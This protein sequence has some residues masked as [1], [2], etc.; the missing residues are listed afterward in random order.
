MGF[1]ALGQISFGFAAAAFV[2]LALVLARELERLPAARTMLAASLVQAVWAGV[3]AFS[4]GPSGM[5]IAA[6][7]VTETLRALAWTVFLLMLPASPGANI[8]GVDASRLGRA[9]GIG[10]TLAIGM[11]AAAIVAGLVGA[12]L[13]MVVGL[14]LIAVTLGLVV[15]EQVNR[16]ADAQQRWTLK[17][18]SISLLAL[19]GFDLLMYSEALVYAQVN[20][21]WWTARGF[22]NALVVPLLLLGAVRLRNWRLELAISHKLAF[23]SLGL[24]AIGIY[25]LLIA[26]GGYYVR[27]LGGSWGSVAQ[28]VLLFAAAIGLL[29]VGLSGSVRASI[30]VLV[31]KHL[32]NYRFDYREEWLRLTR[33]LSEASDGD[34]TPDTLARRALDGICDLVESTG[35]ALWLHDQGEFVF[36][37]GLNHEPT[38]RGFRLSGPAT[39]LLFEREWVVDVGEFGRQPERYPELALPQELLGSNHWLLVPMLLRDTPLGLI[40]LQTPRVATPV[41]WEVRDILKTAAR[42]IAGYIG[43]QRA[44]EAL[45]Q[46]RQF[47]TFNRMSTFVV[48]DLKNLIAQLSLLTQN[49]QRHRGNPEFEADMLDTIENVLARMRG[50]TLQLRAGARPSEPG[51][52]IRLVDLLERTLRS[53]PHLR[54]IPLLEHAAGERALEVHGHPDRLERVIGHLVQNACEACRADGH[55]KLALRRDGNDAVIEVRDDGIGMDR[56]FIANRLFRPFASK[57]ATGMGI[58]AFESREYIRE[59]GG[60]LDVESL[61]GKGTTFRLRLPVRQTHPDENRKESNG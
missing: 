60:T 30:Q 44:T 35:G 10:L 6:I 46:A 48:H 21:A 5:P 61:P 36:V 12:G 34:G 49:A 3:M 40:L 11:A 27:N 2:A 57:K 28:A 55:V 32:F 4:L 9:R 23:R 7:D 58:G 1:A 24:L 51:E 50:L 54:P 47:E 26:A 43:L 20:V 42:E 37:A 41:N 45:V 56:T 15:L 59:I 39:R 16:N 14:R 25:M 8:G 33:L 18:V 22:A 29:V 13:Q 19:F 52:A 31:S 17:F 38:R 53:K